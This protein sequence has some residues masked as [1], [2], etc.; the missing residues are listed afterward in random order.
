MDGTADLRSR[1]TAPKEVRRAQL[2]E[3]TLASIAQ[4]G[5]SG[6]T[7]A[8]VTGRAGLSMGIVSLH[9]KSK[10]NLLTETLRFLA[11]EHRAAWAGIHDDESLTAAQK[12]W[13]I[14]NANFSPQICT[15]EKIAAWFAYFGEAH[16]RA[17]YRDMVEAFDTERAD[18]VEALCGDLAEAGGYAE[19]DPYALTQIIESLADGLWLG[20]L[21]Y[22]DWVSV[23]SAQAQIWGLLSRYFP[24]EFPLGSSPV[25]AA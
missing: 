20:I 1:R 19:V 25:N 10:E 16:Y 8:E 15:E 5:L 23:E 11:E 17:V 6:T 13:A 2:I 12:L 4:N 14:V 18:A 3:A 9:F 21:L 22:D 24:L 7:M